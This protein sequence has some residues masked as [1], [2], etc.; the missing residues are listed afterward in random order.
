MTIHRI[1]A[2][3]A[4]FKRTN[5]YAPNVG[6]AVAGKPAMVKTALSVVA[7]C[8]GLSILGCGGGPT[9]DGSN[10]SGG[11]CQ[12]QRTASSVTGISS[13]SGQCATPV[14]RVSTYNMIQNVSSL[15]INGGAVTVTIYFLGPPTSATESSANILPVKDEIPFAGT[16]TFGSPYIVCTDLPDKSGYR[17]G[18]VLMDE[19][20]VLNGTTYTLNISSITPVY[21]DSIF[22]VHGTLHVDCGYGGVTGGMPPAGQSIALEFSF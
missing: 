18:S 13:F 5:S 15:Y 20:A 2:A 21:M 8:L 11:N 14:V 1:G 9:G 7:T 3:E 19:I 10:S 4:T 6:V 17:W 22:A 12:V 16:S